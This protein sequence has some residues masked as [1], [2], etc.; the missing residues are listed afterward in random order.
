[1]I[2]VAKRVGRLANGL[3][4]FAHLIGAAL[5]HGLTVVNPAFHRYAHHF[6]ATARDL[7]CRF[8][9]GR[10]LPAPPGS[11]ALVY[12]GSR[13]VAEVLHG[14][15][16]RG[17][18]AGLIRLQRDQQLDLNGEGFL[19]V[20]GR[21]RVVLIQDW[22]F[23]N[24][25]NCERHADAIRSFLT[26]WPDHL[27]RARALVTPG[28]RRGRLVVG[29][30]VRQGDYRE[31]LGGRF[32]YT[33]D[34]YRAV[35]ESAERALRGDR[36]VAFLVCSD[37]PLP[38]DAFGDLEVHRGGANA[39]EDL[40]ALAGCDRLVGPPSTFSSWAS[41]Y[42]D[43]PIYRILDPSLPVDGAM[44]QRSVGLAGA[45]ARFQVVAA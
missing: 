31:F 34:Q 24:E 11:R 32:F 22:F 9:P 12:Q 5:E 8:P 20:V 14:M 6:P 16:S 7:L 36:E 10:A 4:L 15:Q 1:M 3:V 17:R 44:F 2:V 42:G 35:M 33:L 13:A 30:H 19:E 18:E 43:V 41:Y 25:Q 29:V 38:P 23:R 28:R 45:D 37:A 40:Y 21:H 27:E 39:L 26:P